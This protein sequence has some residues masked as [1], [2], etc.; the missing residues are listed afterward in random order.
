MTEAVRVRN[1]VRSAVDRKATVLTESS[2]DSD[3]CSKRDGDPGSPEQR[4]D[5]TCHVFT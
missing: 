2:R 4:G 3:V 1:E 5:R